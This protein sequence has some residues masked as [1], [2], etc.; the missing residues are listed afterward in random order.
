MK[1]ARAA[2]GKKKIVAIE[3]V[4]HGHTYGAASVGD[5]C[6]DPMAPGVPEIV[7]LPM[8]R[9]AQGVT[10]L[11]VVTRFE[12]LAREGDVSCFL[13]EPVFTCPGAIIPPPDFYPAIERIC[14]KYAV[15]LALDEVGTGFG[16]CGKLFGYELFGVKPDILCLGKGLTGGY[17]TMGATLVTEEVFERC[18]GIPTYSTF[19]WNPFDLAG[20]RAN[21][22]VIVREKLWESAGK[23]GRVLLERLK[24]LEDLPYVAEVR[25]IG[26][27]L[28]IGIVKDKKSRRPDTRRAQR[29]QDACTERGLLIETAGHRAGW[30]TLFLTPPLILTEELAEQGARILTDVVR[31]G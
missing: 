5:A 29:L 24:P 8:P 17:S 4:Y 22:E 30:N 25:G 31:S 16:R 18:R 23:V 10:T 19:G 12:E 9:V 14:R 2:T 20:A 11:N 7:K 15:L 27:L 26:L 13:S 28:G 21:V 3:G 6:S 1:C